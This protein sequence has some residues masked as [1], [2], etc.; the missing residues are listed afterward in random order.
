M[1][2]EYMQR[3]LD[4][5]LK[6]ISKTDEITSDQVLKWV[7]QEKALRTQVLEAWQ[8]KNEMKRG[9]CRYCKYIYPPQRCPAYGKMCG[10][11]G[12][13]NHLSAVCRAPR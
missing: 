1:N 13:E 3:K 6:V 11:C 10:E 4:S 9:T 5:K 8:T 2:D 12:R 7:K